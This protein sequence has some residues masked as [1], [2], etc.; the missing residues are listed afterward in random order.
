MFFHLQSYFHAQ[1]FY[2]FYQKKV[3][4]L[5]REPAVR[6]LQSLSTGCLQLDV[7]NRNLNFRIK[8]GTPLIRLGAGATCM[9]GTGQN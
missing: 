6:F 7:V 1:E 4:P 9:Y 5:K 8:S 3:I 2:Q